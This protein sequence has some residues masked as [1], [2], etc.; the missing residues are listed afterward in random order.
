[1]NER[2]RDVWLPGFCFVLTLGSAL[3]LAIA[4]LSSP[5]IAGG[6]SEHPIL[7]LFAHDSA[8]RRTSIASALGLAATAFIFFRPAG[9]FRKSDAK[10]DTPSNIAGA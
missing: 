7:S 5:W 8:V 4:V 6:E 3:L 1:M 10:S 9:W 2:L